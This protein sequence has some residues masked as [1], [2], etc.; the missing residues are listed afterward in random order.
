MRVLKEEVLKVLEKTRFSY[1]LL[2]KKDNSIIDAVLFDVLYPKL[3]DLVLKYKDFIQLLGEQVTFE[4][5]NQKGEVINVLEIPVAFNDDSGNI[6][7]EPLH[8]GYQ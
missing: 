8:R 4:I 5:I 6:T 2:I 7:R 1:A 3:F